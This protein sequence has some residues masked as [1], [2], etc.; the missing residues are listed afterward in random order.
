MLTPLEQVFPGL[1]GRVYRVSSPVADKYNCIAWAAGDTS[2]WWWP[3]E[4]DLP[5]SSFWPPAALR[6]ETLDAFLQAFSTLGY[7]RCAGDQEEAGYEKIALFVLDS[8]PA[9]ES[10]LVEQLNAGLA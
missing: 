7:T 6:M 1:R 5:T 10:R 8:V 3:D 2:Q 9:E 4:P